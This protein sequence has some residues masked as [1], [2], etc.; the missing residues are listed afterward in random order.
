MET[1]NFK[2]GQTY[3]CTKANESWWTEGKEYDVGLSVFNEP[4]L[5][6]DDDDRW[7]SNDL[8]VYD[9]TF[10]LKDEQL[11][12]IPKEGQTYICKLDDLDEW[13]LDKEYEVVLDESLGLVIVDDYRGK[14]YMPNYSLL[15]DV[16]KLK[17][18]TFDLNKLT[19]AQLKEYMGLLE[20]KEKSDTLLNEFI[21]R[22]TK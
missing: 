8:S 17:E 13:T 5:A 9:S 19:T 12:I 11:N 14:W 4:F 22:M 15:N 16:F 6:D 7:L 21:E 20:D 3:V 18:K 2:E 10:E 1:L